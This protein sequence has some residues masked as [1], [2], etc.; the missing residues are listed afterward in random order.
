L[1]I[2]QPI[3]NFFARPHQF[4]GDRCTIATAKLHTLKTFV[5]RRCS[6]SMHAFA[7]SL[8]EVDIDVHIGLPG[9]IAMEDIALYRGAELDMLMDS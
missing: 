1:Q 7:E 5:C 2:E 6:D 8:D 4:F 3:V 9:G